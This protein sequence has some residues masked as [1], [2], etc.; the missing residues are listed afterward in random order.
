[1]YICDLNDFAGNFIEEVEP[2]ITISKSGNTAKRRM[3]K[4]RCL[5]QQCS[6]EFITNLSNAKRTKQ[7][8]CCGSC[9]KQ[10]IEH[11]S[12]GNENHPLYSRWLSMKQR[13]LNPTHNNYK[14]YGARGITIEQCFIDSF[15][16]YAE[17]V[18][19]LPNY[20]TSFP[21]KL[22][23]DRIDNDKG[24]FKGN[25]RWVDKS[26]NRINQR[27]KSNKYGSK[28]TGINWSITN[29]A[30]SSRIAYK[31]KKYHLGYFNTQEEAVKV[32]NQYILD[33]NLPHKI[34]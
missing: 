2:V 23:L 15:I 4:L 21:S 22:D 32:R 27:A 29:N 28:Y 1:M 34:Q 7:K 3:V 5:N 17:Y 20:P 33:N 26:I 19:S 30:W 8:C 25:L 13:C 12:G 11:F 31:G 16:E 18:S 10:M 6:K 24:Y 14:N 9:Y